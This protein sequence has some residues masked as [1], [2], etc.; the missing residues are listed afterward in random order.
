LFYGRSGEKLVP[1]IA[2]LQHTASND[3]GRVV[4]GMSNTDR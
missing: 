4:R 1:S 2:L 3:T